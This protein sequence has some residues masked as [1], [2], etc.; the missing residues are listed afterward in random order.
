MN[1]YG[2][3]ADLK[4]LI[5][6][7]SG[8]GDDGVMRS[9]CTAASRWLD[10][11]T[12][13]WFY[14]LIQTRYYDHPEDATRLKVDKDLL[15]VSEFTTQNGEVEVTAD[16]YFL[17]CADSYNLTPYDRIVLKTNS[18]RTQL[19]YTGTLQKANAVTGTWGY[20]EDWGNAWQSSNDTILNATGITTSG[21]SI[22]VADGDGADI[23]G[24]TPRFKIGQ[25][26][27]ADDEFMDLTGISGETLT[28]IRAVNGSTAATHAKD[29]MLYVYRP[30]KDIEDAALALAKWFWSRRE[31]KSFARIIVPAPGVVDIPPGVPLEMV[32]AIGRY[33]T[34]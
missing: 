13:R 2:L 27:K 31:S 33:R 3:M 32:M 28:V 11:K 24:V 16:Q 5:P 10:A 7:Y 26:F 8:T 14:P 19:I 6:D 20:H 4:L 23:F 30:M 34:T 9:I 15:A 18:D 22:T 12:H 21:T 29:V 25:T 17:M 1:E